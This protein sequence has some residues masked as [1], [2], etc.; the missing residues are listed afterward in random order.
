MKF[1]KRTKRNRNPSEIKTQKSIDLNVSIG[2]GLGRERRLLEPLTKKT[3]NDYV[4]SKK[5]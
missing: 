2:T 3:L 5:G 4:P 1:M